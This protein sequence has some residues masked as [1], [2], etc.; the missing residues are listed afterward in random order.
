MP[1]PRS[2]LFL[3]LALGAVACTKTPATEPV[4]PSTP[5]EVLVPGPAGPEGTVAKSVEPPT[6]P[7]VPAVP[8]NPLAPLSQTCVAL[9]LPGEPP[10][11]LPGKNVVVTRLMKPCTTPTGQ[12][13]YEKDTQFLA[14]GVPC[15]GGGGRIDIKGHYGNP[16]MVSFIL[17]TDCSMSPS[18]PE[19]VKKLADE[20]AG[21]PATAKLLAFTPFVVQYWEVTGMTDADTGFS[22]DLR[23]APA[24][25]GAWTRVQKKEP[26]RVRLFGRENT[27]AQGGAFYLVE[28]DLKLTG[29]SQFQ[30]DVQNVKSLSKD[31]VAEVK[32][33]CEAL[34]PA[35]NCSEVF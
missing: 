35:R 30:V 28:A 23:S 29:R 31:E 11:Y 1:T 13:G 2:H 32:G 18:T 7:A 27:W 3:L 22:V 17:G 4:A 6:V 8:V 33:R 14:M 19:T 26:L 16:K 20:V 9:K 12:T 25:E 34:K 24:V 5:S 21:L 10:F 15:T